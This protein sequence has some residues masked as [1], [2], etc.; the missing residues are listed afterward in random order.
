M[1]TPEQ[2]TKFINAPGVDGLALF[3]IIIVLIMG[4]CGVLAIKAWRR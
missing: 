4:A 3:V 2:V 1:W